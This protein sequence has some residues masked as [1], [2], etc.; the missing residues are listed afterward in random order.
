MQTLRFPHPLILLLIGIL[1]ASLL[2]YIIPAGKYERRENPE[3]GRM[4]VVPGSYNQVAATPVS[5][6]HAMVKIPK[7]LSGAISVIAFV[8]L[9]GAAFAV[10]DQTGA[11]RWS[12]DWLLTRL[13]S[14]QVLV[15]PVACLVFAMGGILTNMQE[16]FIA[17]VPVLLLLTQR[18]GYDSLTAVAIS[19]GAAAVGASFSPIN[20]FQVG[21]AQTLS[22]V[23][24]LSGAGF[25]MLFLGLALGIWIWGTMRYAARTRTVPAPMDEPMKPS[26][27][28]GNNRYGLIMLLVLV[29]FV[30]FIVGIMRFEW[31]FD[32]LGILFF[33]MGWLAG[34]LG[35]LGIT[36][37]AKAFVQGFS[38][39]AFAA[40]LIGFAQSIFVVLESGQ[41]IDTIV[42]TLSAPLTQLPLALSAIGMMLMHVIIHF[43]VPSVT[44]QA[45]LTL[46]ILVPLS[47]LLGL[48]RQVTVLA[49]QYGAGLCELLTP[50]NGALMAVLAAAGA[51]FDKWLRFVL[52]LFVLLCAL[53]M[54]AI[55]LAIVSGL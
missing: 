53:G 34:W 20:P 31:G 35:G 49:Y 55:T 41:I 44:G 7:G 10:V 3:T 52:P 15:I 13:Q 14:R 48:S 33:M 6:W 9:V 5:P 50:T 40:L 37:T 11:L 24:L 36:G 16:E 29:A 19:A 25:R 2:G 47:D 42:Y 38:D 54:V 51:G 23:P 4:V 21:I 22:E 30:L 32:E 18:L 43:P 39:M 8:F 12:V 28:S 26:H 1:L 27:P 46:P 17:L 45:A